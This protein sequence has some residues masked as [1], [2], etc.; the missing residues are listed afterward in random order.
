M[1]SISDRS[2]AQLLA[3]IGSKTPAPGGGAVASAC[4]ALAAALAKMVVAYS[5]GKKNLAEHQPTLERVGA[6]LERT[7]EM[8]LT[9][10]QEDA[11]AYALVNELS[12]L[13]AED[14]RRMAEYPAAVE[15]AV[16]APRS[17]VGVCCD[18]LRM[19]E[20]LTTASNRHLRSDLAIAAILAEAAAKSGWWNVN[21]NLDLLSDESRRATLR[22]ECQKMLAEAATRRVHIERACE[23]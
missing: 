5:L 10:A 11:E 16:Q 9:L 8:L 22:A 23:G 2:F 17:V 3:A 20:P 1:S 14:P 12:K 13:P 19:L 18:L 6:A 7:M 4:G 15:A 21:V